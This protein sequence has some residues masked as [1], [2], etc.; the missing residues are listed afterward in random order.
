MSIEQYQRTVNN[1]DK[2]I[3]TLEQKKTSFDKKA[4]DQEKKAAGVSISRNASASTINSKKIQIER[5]NKESNKAKEQSAN[6][7]K[8]IADKRKKRNDAYS[9]LQKEQHLEIK[10]QN[11]LIV[12]M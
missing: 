11:N 8:K 6:L 1:L 3:A 9:K 7:M 2:E 12:N 5:Y 10:R 4:A